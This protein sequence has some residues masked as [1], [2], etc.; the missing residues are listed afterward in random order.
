MSIVLT[1]I[2]RISLCNVWRLLPK[3]TCRVVGPSPNWYI[4]N[5][6]PEPKARVSLQNRDGKII[7]ARGIRSY[8]HEVSPIRLS[9]DEI[10]RHVNIEKSHE[11]P[12]EDWNTGNSEMLRIEKVSSSEKTPI[13]YKY[14]MH[15]P[16][17]MSIQ[18]SS[19][20]WV[21]VFIYLEIC[22]SIGEQLKEETVDFKKSLEELCGRIWKEEREEEK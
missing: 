19:Y 22:V 15:R 10:N 16:E 13:V 17:N 6:S 8:T 1:P 14:Q 18:V 11:V 21:E 12:G 9:E 5:T 20:D 3:T 2:K 7:R 4:Y